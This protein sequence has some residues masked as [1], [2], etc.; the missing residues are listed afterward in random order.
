MDHAL[1]PD[2]SLAPEKPIVTT[3]MD[4]SV[5]TPK[6]M[7]EAT[8]GSDDTLDHSSS[9]SD[10][11]TPSMND[12]LKDRCSDSH[13]YN[14]RKGGNNLDAVSIEASL[15]S[16]CLEPSMLLY[17]SHGMA[18]HLSPSQLDALELLITNQLDA[19]RKA[20]GIQNR[21][22]SEPVIVNLPM[23][24]NPSSTTL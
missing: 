12:M 24:S 16:L 23:D 14:L 4:G 3:M 20:K 7:R 8:V 6:A 10:V 17:T 18:L 11:N 5:M 15:A 1:D 9:Q 22:L 2:H 21:L 13:Q 19:V